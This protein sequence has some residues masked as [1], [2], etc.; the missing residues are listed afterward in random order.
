[1]AADKLPQH[2]R[3]GECM[4]VGGATDTHPSSALLDP[5]WIEEHQ[6]QTMEKMEQ[7][8][9]FAEGVQV[10]SS[11]KNLAER[12]TDIFGVEETVIGQKVGLL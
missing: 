8:V 6:R 3:H 2:M 4:R 11:L 12:R 1:M 9:V 10:G 7:E 5:R